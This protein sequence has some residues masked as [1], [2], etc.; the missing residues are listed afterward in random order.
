VGG[1]EPVKRV[2]ARCE[3]EEGCPLYH[4]G[5]RISFSNVA[6]DGVDR[7]PVCYR[8]VIKFIVT[9]DKIRAGSPPWNFENTF[10]GG[11]EHGKAWFGFST[12]N[13]MRS[14]RTNTKFED[15][16][17][18]ALSKIK[19]FAGVHATTMRRIVPLLRERSVR[20]AEVI[21]RTGER[22]GALFLIVGGR[23]DVVT[24]DGK[25]EKPV[26]TLARGDCVGE[27]SLVTGEPS[28]ATVVSCGVG[29]VLEVPATE[30]PTL[31]SL[32]PTLG[33]G[34]ARDV[35]HRISRMGQVATASERDGILG[36]LEVVGPAELVQ[37]MHLNRQSGVLTVQCDGTRG[38]VAFDEGEVVDARLGDDAGEEAFYA[39]LRWTRG[40]FRFEA[41]R[42]EAARSMHRDTMGLLLEGMR[43]IDES[44]RA[45]SGA[46]LTDPV[47]GA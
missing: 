4:K 43:R 25:T 39:F 47:T 44:A 21:V 2:T 32:V 35:L 18:A 14:V 22:V 9:V 20:A 26:M 42:Q 40:S 12:A 5:D 30:F 23:F 27:M 13:T 15:F 10:C 28:Q 17:L 41:G 46:A 19:L 3:R 6:V 33:L 38:T 24:R 7:A 37:A 29:Q 1:V 11:C 16:A 36:R 31:L 34:L 45:A 8:A